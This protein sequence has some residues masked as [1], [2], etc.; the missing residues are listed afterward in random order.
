ML[1]RAEKHDDAISILHGAVNLA[2]EAAGPKFIPNRELGMAYKR[3]G[4]PQLAIDRLK[5]AVEENPGDRDTHGIIGGVHK[6]AYEIE[7]A[8]DSYQRG[9][10]VDLRST[11]CLL[12]IICLLI[13]RGS[14]GDKLRYKRLL[15]LANKLTFEAMDSKGA[16]HWTAFDRAHYL[17]YAGDKIGALDLFTKAIEKTNTIGELRSARKNLDLLI[18]AEANIEGLDE[19]MTLFDDAES[20]FSK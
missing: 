1:S 20:G 17:L 12:N 9:F 2:T 14:I 6:E 11:Y 19:I 10:D 18:E 3:A 5:K 7:K 16:D 4:K 15:P 13:V 8:I